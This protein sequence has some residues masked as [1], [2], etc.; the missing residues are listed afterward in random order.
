MYDNEKNEVEV[1]LDML[2]DGN[3]DDDEDDNGKSLL[4]RAWF[5]AL[6][7][8]CNIVQTVDNILKYLLSNRAEY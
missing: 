8:V 1:E 4:Y 2:K 7:S 6:F 5:Y 3:E